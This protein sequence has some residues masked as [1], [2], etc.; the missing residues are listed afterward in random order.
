MQE[1]V[2]KLLAAARTNSLD[3]V[4]AAFGGVGQACK[5]CHDDYRNQ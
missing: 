1:E 3:N 5:A 2:A 4:K